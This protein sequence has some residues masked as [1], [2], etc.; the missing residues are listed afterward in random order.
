MFVKAWLALAVLAGLSIAAL[1]IWSLRTGKRFGFV[2]PFI[3]GAVT[4]IALPVVTQCQYMFLDEPLCSAAEDGRL[5]TIKT[6]VEA[7][8]NVN[9]E[10]DD[11]RGTPLV[12]ASYEGHREI[13]QYLIAHD[14]D[15]NRKAEYIF[16]GKEESEPPTL[17]PLQAAAAHPDILAMLKKAGA[18]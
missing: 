3:V 16:A 12:A 6:L 18:K 13:V 2:L 1:A 14:A 15:V 10:G 8:A 4:V 7:G 9:A 11:G 5:N 17:T